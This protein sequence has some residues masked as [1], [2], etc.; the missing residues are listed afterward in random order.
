MN[1]VLSV[2]PEQDKKPRNSKSYERVTAAAMKMTAQTHEI[3][4]N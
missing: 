2:V 1:Q 4:E 3:G